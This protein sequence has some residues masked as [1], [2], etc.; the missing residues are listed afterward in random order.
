MKLKDIRIAK[1]LTQTEAASIAGVSVESY[2]NHELGRSKIESPLG[3]MILE[4]ISSYEKYS[5]DRG[6]LKLDEIKATLFSVLPNKE[7]TFAYLFGPYAK[8]EAV[9]HSDVDLMIFGPITGLDFFSL[10][11]ELERALH[12]KIDLIRFEDVSSN[13]KLIEEIMK[14]GIRI[15]EKR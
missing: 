13:V 10:G 11:G 8:G 9:E 7:I 15:Y 12:K 6:V 2:K 5:F 4:K 3:K 14:T 1:G